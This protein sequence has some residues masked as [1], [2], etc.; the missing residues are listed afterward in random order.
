MVAVDAYQIAAAEKHRQ[1]TVLSQAGFVSFGPPALRDDLF[2]ALRAE[3]A[4][5]RRSGQGQSGTETV[6]HKAWRAS[7][8]PV[9]RQFLGDA[10]TLALLRDLVGCDVTPR[11]EA[12]C[13]TYYEASGEYPEPHMD[14]AETCACTLTVN[15]EA[16]WPVGQEPGKGLE[17]PLFGDPTDPK[18]VT[19]HIATRANA[20]VI[21]RG[22]E[23]PHGRP[24]LQTGERVVTLTACF[25]A[26]D[27]SAVASD[28]AATAAYGGD[29]GRVTGVI[30]D[31]FRAWE[32]GKYQLAHERFDCALAID[33]ASDEA[34]S[35][36]GFVLWS[37]GAFEGAGEAFTNAARCN[38]HSP[39]HWSNIG[40]C[41]RETGRLEEA[42]AT[43]AIAL[44]LDADYAPALN[45]WGNVLQDGGQS[46]DAVDFY[47]RA[48]ALDPA[49]AAVHHNLGVA[50]TRQNE[51]HLALQAFLA[52][53]ERDPDYPPALTEL[54]LLYA[55]AG[56]TEAAEE[57]LACAGTE[58]AANV[59][60]SL[61]ER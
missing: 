39:S 12:S 57:L 51:P 19:G 55:Q 59:L 10:S 45:E 46:G 23:I 42:I 8:G 35:G 28:Q 56:A 5:Q 24:A 40:L 15:L 6:D 50:Y 34:W 49:R 14:Q 30:D 31:G 32:Q 37:E 41:L 2:V 43:F 53:L 13:F 20:I 52:A 60:E 29:D 21:G 4:F 38:G 1:R 26:A 58:R 17:L 11:F 16:D 61:P 18:R 3:A 47:F 27:R 9:A 44:M 25:A 54:G 48:L 22:A 7:P 36:K 33:D